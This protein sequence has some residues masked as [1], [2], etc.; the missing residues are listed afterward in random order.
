MDITVV[1]T[2]ETPSNLASRK[3]PLIFLYGFLGTLITCEADEL[4][5][6]RHLRNNL[7]YQDVWGI[8]FG[9]E[10]GHLY[11]EMKGRIEDTNT[12]FFITKEELPQN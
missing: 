5:E 7:K 3:F 1:L 10:I 8:Y 6:Y 11:Q 4:F 9:N 2:P 12:I